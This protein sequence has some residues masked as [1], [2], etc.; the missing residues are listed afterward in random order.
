MT[1]RALPASSLTGFARNDYSTWTPERRCEALDQPGLLRSS[2]A[3]VGNRGS[4]IRAINREKWVRIAMVGTRGVPAS[5]SG[6]ETCAEEVG[7]RLARRGHTVAVYGR[8]HHLTYRR[9]TYRGVRVVKL[10]TIRNK[11][12]DTMV[13]ST[14][15]A[16]HAAFSRFDA[17]LVFGV[18]SSPVALIPR[19][20]G[21]AV[22][23]NVDGLD[24][25]RGKW[26]ASARSYLRAA[27]RLA[28]AFGNAVI[29]DSRAVQEYYRTR[30]GT[31]TQYIP[32]GAELRS[33]PPN[34]AL[35]RLQLE[36]R[37]YLLYVGRLVP[38]NC[39]DHLVEAF[40][41]LDTDLKCVIVGDA[42]YAEEYIARLKGRAG[43]NVIFPGYVFGEDYWE[44]NCN[45]FAYVFTSGAAGTHPALLEALAC[46]NCVIAQE[47]ATN[48]E[49]AAGSALYYDGR[50]GPEDL[51]RQ[52]RHIIA[53]PSAVIQYGDR[54]QREIAARYSW[55]RVTDAYEQLFTELIAN[56]VGH[57]A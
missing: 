41:Q 1:R 47:T 51:L 36:P 10:P 40:E 24:W 38:E 48:R 34:G 21:S 3:H 9:S 6:F 29:T 42:P 14:L 17:V 8:S 12:L 49:V 15:S 4:P 39:A 53:H 56:R 11:Y 25:Q 44:L 30:H 27:E 31:A 52:L 54:A 32:Y 33:D 2:R 22:A 28:L 43:R 16:I 26:P 23:I 46:G 55:E 37:K 35:R 45:A 57:G 50:A 5:Y 7:S 19:L 18:G 20:T 13:H